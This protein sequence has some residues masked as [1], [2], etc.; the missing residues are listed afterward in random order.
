MDEKIRICQEARKHKERVGG[1]C[2]RW[3][4]LVPLRWTMSGKIGTDPFTSCTTQRRRRLLLVAWLFAWNLLCLA[5][6]GGDFELSGRSTFKNFT[7]DGSFHKQFSGSFTIRKSGDNWM[8]NYSPDG[9]SVTILTAYDGTNVYCLTRNMA[10]SAATTGKY[11]NP[12]LRFTMSNGIAYASSASI[13]SGEYPYVAPAIPVRF[14]WFAFLSDSILGNS[15]VNKFQFPA[16]WANA[17]S[18]EARSFWIRVERST[19]G[20]TLPIKADF[21]ASSELWS[22]AAK[23]QI[24]PEHTAN[25]FPDKA[26]G[27]VYT[28]IGWT[29]LVEE[30]R[31]IQFPSICQLERYW[32][33]AGDGGKSILA[34]SLTCEVSGLKLGK[35]D[36]PDIGMLDIPEKWIDVFDARFQD[37]DYPTISVV[38]SLTNHEWK[39]T[40]DADVQRLLAY[41]KTQY[42]N[43][44]TNNVRVGPR[45]VSNSMTPH[46]RLVRRII[47]TTLCC[48]TFVGIPLVLFL[49]RHRRKR[50]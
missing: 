1:F 27:G 50:V 10:V 46:Q 44:R 37:E 49:V 13:S 21:I 45:V 26:T 9:N 39:A 17:S 34:E 14:L 11:P 47:A 41:Y 42:S 15:G 5:T 18:P 38:Y 23:S 25:P 19:N 8:I 28:V 33:P 40:N 29:N 7:P 24:R 12:A 35:P 32:P 2:P 43:I 16:L 4:A 31:V 48:V 30:G 36:K 3:S 6:Y 22:N 20:T